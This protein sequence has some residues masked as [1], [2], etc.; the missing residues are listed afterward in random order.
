ME[1][2]IIEVMNTYGYIGIFLLIALENI[3]P[4]I[5]S[6]VILTFGGFMTTTTNLSVFWVII[7]STIGSV[8]GAIILYGIGVLLNVDRLERIVDKWGHILRITSKDIKKADDWFHRFGVWTIFFGRL[9]PLIRRLISI[10]AGMSHM[11]KKTYK[12]YLNHPFYWRA[13]LYEKN[14]DY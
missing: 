3:F 2:W 13:I 11:N 8:A 12:D 4:P 5:P 14:I 1:K 10:P 6:E 7:V 9:V